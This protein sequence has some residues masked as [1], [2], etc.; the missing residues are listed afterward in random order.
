MN[1]NKRMRR[2]IPV[3]NVSLKEGATYDQLS[4]IPEMKTLVIETTKN[5]II[6]GIKKNKKSITLFEIAN[7]TYTI[8]LDKS[9]WVTSLEKMIDYYAEKEDYNACISIK[10]LIKQIK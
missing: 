4:E 9:Q 2:K 7:T 10:D 1:K 3:L 8:D 6:D 5:A